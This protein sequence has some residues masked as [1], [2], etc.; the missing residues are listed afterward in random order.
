M[1]LALKLFSDEIRLCMALAGVV[2]VS[3]ISKEYL[4]KIDKSGFVSRL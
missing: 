4:V 2:H 3:D 1:E